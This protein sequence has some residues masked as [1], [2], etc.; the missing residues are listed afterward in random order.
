V[1]GKCDIDYLELENLSDLQ[2]LNA[3]RVMVNVESA[4]LALRAGIK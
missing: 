1:V 4:A 2:K 3:V